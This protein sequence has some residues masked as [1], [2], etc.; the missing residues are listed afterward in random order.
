MS[1]TKKGWMIHPT[2]SSS[3]FVGQMAKAF[4]HRNGEKPNINFRR[5]L[6]ERKK[7]HGSL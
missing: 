6:N 2:F 1:E 7:C 5:I 3:S 4:F